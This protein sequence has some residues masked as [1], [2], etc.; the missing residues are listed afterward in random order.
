MIA[1]VRVKGVGAE[2]AGEGDAPACGLAAEATSADG[3]VGVDMM[4]QR[5]DKAEI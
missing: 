1:T 2:T 5:K 4:N 3:E